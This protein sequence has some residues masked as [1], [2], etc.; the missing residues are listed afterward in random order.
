MTINV[1]IERLILEGLPPE[2]HQGPLLQRELEADLVRLFAQ[3][4]FPAN[5]LAGTPMPVLRADTVHLG[6]SVAPQLWGR[7]I[8]QAVYG[9]IVK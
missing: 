8:A 5:L 7:Q 6:A 2:S 3:R 4:P 1:H 9:A